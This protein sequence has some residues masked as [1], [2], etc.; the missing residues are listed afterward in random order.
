MIVEVNYKKEKYFVI[1]DDD[2]YI[3]YKKYK[4]CLIKKRNSF[5]LGRGQWDSKNK[6][7]K[8]VYFHRLILNKTSKMIDHING[9]TL[10]NRKCN[11]RLATNQQNIANQKISKRNTSGY[12]GVHLKKYNLKNPYIAYITCKNIR[13]HLGY[14]KTAEEAATA[15]NNAAK[16]YFGEFAALNEVK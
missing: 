2:D 8:I 15:Y 4:W 7:T 16:K 11:L 13:Y 12:K 3:F 14:F 9:N 6:T 1:I 5:Y 10:D